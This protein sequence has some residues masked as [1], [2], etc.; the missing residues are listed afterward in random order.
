MLPTTRTAFLAPFEDLHREIDRVF[1]C[2]VDRGRAEQGAGWYPVDIRETDDHLIVEAEMPG[3][4]KNEV[5]ITL[6]N[7]VLTITAE[8]KEEKA[9]GQSH[10]TERRIR[11]VS[12]AFRLPV[13]VDENKVEATLNDGVLTLSLNKRDEVKPRRI[14]VK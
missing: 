9:E 8:R 12:R 11:R 3:F 14:E 5:N 7:K 4:K 13:E 6:E 2:A 1:N 10:L